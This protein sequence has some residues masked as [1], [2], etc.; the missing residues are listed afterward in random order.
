MKKD[1]Q[2][3]PPVEDVAIVAVIEEEHQGELEWSIYLFNMKEHEIQTVLVSSSGYGQVDGRDVKTS[4]L[5]YF[6]EDVPKLSFRKIEPIKDDLFVLHN[7]YWVSFYE[8]GRLL[9]KK[10]TFEPGQITQENTIPLPFIGKKGVLI[11]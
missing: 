2:P 6:L 8:N 10:F 9:D 1:I 11:R 5:R 3:T 4:T 7:E